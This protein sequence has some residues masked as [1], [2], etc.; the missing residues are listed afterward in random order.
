[1]AKLLHPGQQ[2]SRLTVLYL[3]SIRGK[4]WS[5]MYTCQCTCW[6]QTTVKAVA[7]RLGITRSCG[8]LQKET[9]SKCNKIDLIGKTF[10]R[11]T[12]ISEDIT[13]Y[14]GSVRYHCQCTCGNTLTVVSNSLTSWNTKSCWCLFID[15][16][17]VHG[18]SKTIEYRTWADMKQRCLN[19]KN[20]RYQDYWWRWITVCPQ[21]ADSFEQFYKDMGPRPLWKSID[22]IDNNGHYEPSNCRWATLKEQANNK[23]TNV[24]N[25]TLPKST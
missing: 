15:W 24:K 13:R 23:S 19:H 18:Q 2:F 3:E 14:N 17:F 21:W 8:C 16:L 11:L 10:G 9:A 1:M 12:V 22:R 4:D 5:R 6:K 25:K 20:K 7:L